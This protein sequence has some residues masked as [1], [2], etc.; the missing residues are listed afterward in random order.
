M[1]ALALAAALEALRD[2]PRRQYSTSASNDSPRPR[3]WALRPR[4]PTPFL[5]IR[6]TGQQWKVGPD[7]PPA[8]EH[9]VCRL[10][11]ARRWAIWLALVCRC[12]FFDARKLSLMKNSASDGIAFSSL[13]KPSNGAARNAGK[14]AAKREPRKAKLWRPRMAAPSDCPRSVSSTAGPPCSSGPADE[15]FAPRAQKHSGRAF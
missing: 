5:S 3:T 7:I 4:G 12:K 1:R 10:W 6:P 9:V 15:I 13:A 8:S 2:R 14:C 11:K